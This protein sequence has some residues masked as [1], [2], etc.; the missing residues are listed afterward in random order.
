MA[1]FADALVIRPGD[2]CSNFGEYRLFCFSVS[3]G[4]EF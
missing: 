1:E 3:V 4:I 2:P